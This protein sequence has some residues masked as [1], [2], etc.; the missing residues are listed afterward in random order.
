MVEKGGVEAW[1][2]ASCEDF[3]VDPA[4]YRKITDTVDVWFD[5]GT[6]ALHGA[7][8]PG[9]AALAR[10]PLPR[11]QRPAPRLVPVEPAHR[12]R[13]GRAARPTTRCSPTAS[14]STARAARCPS[15][16]GNVIAPQKVIAD[17][18]GAEIL[19]LWVASTDYSG[20]LAISDEILKRVVESYRRIRNTLRFLLANTADFDPARDALPVSEWVEIDRYALAMTREMAAAC[21]ADY[22]RFE[23]H[24]VAQRLQ[25]FCSED[26][27]G[28][29]LDILKDRLYTNGAK[30]RARRSAQIG[31]APRDP[32]AAAPHGAD[33]V[34]HR[35]GS[36]GGAAIPART[37]ASS[38]TPGTTCFRSRQARPSSCARW[39]R[40]REIRAA[41]PEE[42][43][44]RARRR[45]HRFVA[46]GRSRRGR[47]GRRPR[48][49]ALAG[50]RPQVRLHHLRRHGARRRRRRAGGGGGAEQAR[51]VRALL[52][53]A[54]A[55][56]GSDA[57]HATICGRCVAN[58]E[59]AGRGA[60]PCLSARR[61]RGGAGSPLSG[62]VVA[63][64][65]ATKA[66]MSSAFRARR[67]TSVL[68]FFNLVLV[69][70][71]GAAFSFLAGAGGWQRWFFTVVAVAIS[72]FIV[73]MLKRGAR[74]RLLAFGLALILG[75]ALGNLWDRVT[76]RPRG[77]L[78]PAARRGLAISRPSTSP[79]PPSRSAWRCSSGIACS[80]TRR[81]ARRTRA[82]RRPPRRSHERH[83]RRSPSRQAA[84]LLRRRRSRHRDRRARARP[85][86]RADLR[87]PRDRAQ[88]VRG[89][90]P[91]RQG[92]GLRRG[93]GRSAVGL[94]RD[95]LRP[96]RIPRR[97]PRSRRARPQGL[98]RH[99]PAGHQGARRSLAHARAG[100]RSDHD[101]PRGPPRGRGHHGPVGGRHVPR[102]KRGGCREPARAPIPPSSPT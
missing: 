80:G 2:A 74:N 76:P 15:R 62:A 84:R 58:L 66:W 1:F 46:A 37:K 78:H 50:R 87:A 81:P 75:G 69:H 56:S 6:I 10:G 3:G 28:F 90:G 44:G 39:K 86:R 63:L 65:L 8:R 17:T 31:A 41:V 51:E 9:G 40:I 57:R 72:A 85:A 73:V 52:A 71:T 33:P 83:Q 92:R 101:R 49:A 47:A 12:L 96:R 27:G 36:L 42:A 24:L 35:R 60:R 55:T 68:P 22:A 20:E 4:Q 59:G 88:Q 11:G 97:A 77:R 100:P 102:G 45:R 38:S 19:R 82:W 64:D 43:R 91:A 30:S 32:G 25:N 21:A 67:G 18:L 79:I 89:R 7:A 48:A 93:A 53:L 70:N 95:L 34:L 94:D 99:L 16:S 14:P 54:R 5:S 98:R 13:H 61:G 29:W 23:F 26:L